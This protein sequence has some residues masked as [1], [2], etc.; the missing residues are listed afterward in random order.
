VKHW[1]HVAASSSDQQVQLPL[2]SSSILTRPDA[3]DAG[4]VVKL[5]DFGIARV[6]STDTELAKTAVSGSP[7]GS[8][9]L[10]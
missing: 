7:L 1:S 3:D 6:L 9:R 5:G 4:N 8:T 10:A 2:S